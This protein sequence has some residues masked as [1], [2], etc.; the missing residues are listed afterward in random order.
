MAPVGA[1]CQMCRV[2]PEMGHGDT[3]VPH[4]PT[5]PTGE[6]LSAIHG[7]LGCQD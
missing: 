3:E 5:L 2:L 4:S 6:T 1:P 7:D